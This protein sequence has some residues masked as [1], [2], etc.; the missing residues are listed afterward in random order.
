[1]KRKSIIILVVVLLII[2]AV[3]FGVYKHVESSLESLKHI[4]IQDVD[5]SKIQDGVYNG[6]YA[7]T[8]VSVEVSV[9]VKDH[10]IT[11]ITIV[12]HSNGQGAP[13][14]VITD[15]V[16]KSQTL[17]VDAVTGATYSSKAIL[18]AIKDA[19]TDNDN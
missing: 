5:M 16:I 12:K 14:E 19:L 17:Q 10:K 11:D 15:S 18:L 9:T 1:M 8:L 6:S 2:S 7:A 13:A 4:E 3:V